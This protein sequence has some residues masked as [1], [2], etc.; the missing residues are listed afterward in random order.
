GASVGYLGEA[1]NSVGAQLVGAMPG[2]G[3]LS[4]GQM[5]GAEGEAT[6]KACLL[7]NIEP[8]LDAAN[9]VAAVAACNAAEMVVALTSFRSAGHDIADVMLPIAPFT[10]TSGT[11]VSAEGRV[12]GAHGVVKPLG[13]TRPAWKVLRVLGNL[14]GLEGFDFQS[15]E[16]VRAEALGDLASIP[17]RLD[18][19]SATGVAERSRA[20]A[21][22]RG[23]GGFERIADIPIYATDGVVRRAS[24]LQL[25]ADA[26]PPVVGV[27]RAVSVRLGLAPGDS[28]RVSQ[29]G[30]PVVLAASIDATLADNVLRVPAG[31]PDTAALGPMFGSITVEKVGAGAEPAAAARG[32]FTTSAPLGSGP[33]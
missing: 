30:A 7:L 16:D 18:N 19:R 29:G 5:L 6:L 11:Y 12:Q 10:E 15:S 33:V 20:D 8:T 32:T 27:P 24:S 4:A 1:A 28:V 2:P 23:A 22:A 14:L 21:A 26:R 3:G 9:A 25:T 31:H 17:A 13:D